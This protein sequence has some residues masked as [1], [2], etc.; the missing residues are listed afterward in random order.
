MKVSGKWYYA[1][2]SGALAINT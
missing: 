2:S 1:Y